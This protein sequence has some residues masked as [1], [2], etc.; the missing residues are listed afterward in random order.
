LDAD[1]DTGRQAE[2]A[3]GPVSVNGGSRG[4]EA[5]NGSTS[6][7][8]GSDGDTETLATGTWYPDPEER[9]P[10]EP[11]RPELTGRAPGPRD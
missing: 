10:F 9:D 3:S 6:R 4:S 8:N 1:V 11:A 2:S 5:G 7:G